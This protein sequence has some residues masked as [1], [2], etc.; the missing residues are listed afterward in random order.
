MIGKQPSALVITM[1]AAAMLAGACQSASPAVPAVLVHA[2]GDTISRL[3]TQLAKAMGRPQIELGPGD[4]T[5]SSRLSVLPPKP[6]PLEDR[7]LAK[8]TI[9]LIQLEGETCT[10]IREDTGARIA[11]EGVNCRAAAP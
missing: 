7:S 3:K 2:D 4:P 11:L 8:P 10:L 6:G 5:Q 1:V 9:F